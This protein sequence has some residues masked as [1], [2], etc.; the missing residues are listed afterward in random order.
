MQQVQK[1]RDCA[2]LK[3]LQLEIC[4]ASDIVY[5]NLMVEN[6]NSIS[7]MAVFCT[8]LLSSAYN[9]YHL[10]VNTVKN[11]TL[12]FSTRLNCIETTSVIFH[13]T[14]GTQTVDS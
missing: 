12:F 3:S 5:N 11:K 13:P 14:Y 8:E 6:S 7:Y 9:L 10:I 4:V 2:G 1:I